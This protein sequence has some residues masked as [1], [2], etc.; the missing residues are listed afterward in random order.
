MQ[1]F[2][3]IVKCPKCGYKQKT[4]TIRIVK[5]HECLRNFTVMPIMGIRQPKIRPR[6]IKVLKGSA[7]NEYYKEKNR[8]YYERKKIGRKK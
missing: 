1:G 3:A 5:C 7:T 8:L 6:I 2:L 4:S